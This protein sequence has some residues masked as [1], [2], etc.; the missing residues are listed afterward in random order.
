[1]FLAPNHEILIQ[2]KKERYN[3]GHRNK[4]VITNSKAEIAKIDAAIKVINSIK[5]PRKSV[6]ENRF[7]PMSSL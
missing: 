1:M 2:K 3:R 4:S 6:N 7:C 5:K